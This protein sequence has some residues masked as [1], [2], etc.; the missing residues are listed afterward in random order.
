MQNFGRDPIL[1]ELR[2]HLASDRFDPRQRPPCP[3]LPATGWSQGDLAQ[4]LHH[5]GKGGEL[6]RR[7]PDWIDF[8]AFSKQISSLRQSI[9]TGREHGRFILSDPPSG[10]LV[11]GGT[12]VGTERR[13]VVDPRMPDSIRL[14]YPRA[15]AT[16]MMHTHPPDPGDPNAVHHFSPQDFKALLF[17]P[18]LVASIVIAERM[19][20]LVLKSSAT[21]QLSPVIFERVLDDFV[22]D[23]LGRATGHSVKEFTKQVCR[24]CAL[25]LMRAEVEAPGLF[26]KVKLF[27]E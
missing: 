21:R 4:Y 20:L 27:D 6:V 19:S 13:V 26:R 14:R 2:K 24:T 5:V 25:T 12:C 17:N 15:I 22:G 8:G 11:V 3:N 1:D 18:S 10:D 16:V 23:D 9:A 7:N